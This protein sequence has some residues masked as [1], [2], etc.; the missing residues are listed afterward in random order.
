MKAI[1]KSMFG[2][3]D[4]QAPLEADSVWAPGTAG[5]LGSSA[6][7]PVREQHIRN[8]APDPTIGIA[9]I[10]AAMRSAKPR[11]LFS[12]YALQPQPVPR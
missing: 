4:F 1:S 12:V 3:T 10:S 2:D 9:A 11:N 5:C 7:A 6:F 8:A